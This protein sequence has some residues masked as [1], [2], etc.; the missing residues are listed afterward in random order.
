MNVY[1]TEESY[2]KTFF[3]SIHR[4]VP[5]LVLIVTSHIKLFICIVICKCTYYVNTLTLLY[6]Y[7]IL[8]ERQNNRYTEPLYKTL[9]VSRWTHILDVS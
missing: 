4:K 3:T 9:A 8:N 2:F 6:T 5:S 7:L 1:S